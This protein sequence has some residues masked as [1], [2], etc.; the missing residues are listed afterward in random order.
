MTYRIVKNDK[1]IPLYY[2]QWFNI[3][4]NKWEEIGWGCID[5]YHVLWAFTLK[6]AQRKL[7]KWRREQKEPMVVWKGEL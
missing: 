2:P 7:K 5:D 6:G 4:T 3:E 1:L